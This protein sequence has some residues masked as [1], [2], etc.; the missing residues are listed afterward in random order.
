MKFKILVISLLIGASNFA[1]AD[2]KEVK[3]GVNGMVC[4]FCAQGITKKFKAEKAVSS[5]DVK[6]SDKQVNLKLNHEAGDI[7]DEKIK[8]LLTDSGYTVTKIERK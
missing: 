8:E 3:V 7:T 2:H 4:G 5:V 6:L 1:L